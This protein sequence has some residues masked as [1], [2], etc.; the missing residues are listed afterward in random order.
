[1]F[2]ASDSKAYKLW[3]EKELIVIFI[4]RRAEVKEN[5]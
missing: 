3:R 4:I 5:D 2:V 1:V